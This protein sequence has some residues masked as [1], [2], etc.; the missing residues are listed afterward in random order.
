MSGV[1]LQKL[2]SWSRKSTY[3][4][5]FKSPVFSP[6]IQLVTQGQLLS[7]A[8]IWQKKGQKQTHCLT[9]G[10]ATVIIY[11]NSYHLWMLILCQTQGLHIFDALLLSLT[12]ILWDS[13]SYYKVC[14]LFLFLFI[15][16][17]ILFCLWY[18]HNPNNLCWS[19]S[20]NTFSSFLQKWLK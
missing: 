10:C 19:S 13:V 1:E 14:L 5:K 4:E 17:L 18:C 8:H 6:I 12:T 3:L 16:I 2:E 11:N 9:F 15:L 7:Q 20:D